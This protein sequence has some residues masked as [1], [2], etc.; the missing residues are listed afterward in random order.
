MNLMQCKPREKLALFD[1]SAYLKT[2]KVCWSVETSIF[3]YF[4]PDSD[5]LID[6]CFE[7]DYQNSKVA[8]LVK[9]TELNE[10]REI[11][12]VFYR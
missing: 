12:K 2:K 8:R 5:N 10:S 9:E 3:R 6:E 4:Q 1:F 7:F 11:L